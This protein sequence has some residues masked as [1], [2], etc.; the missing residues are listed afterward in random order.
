MI[1]PCFPLLLMRISREELID[2]IVRQRSAVELIGALVVS[3]ISNVLRDVLLCHLFY[4]IFTLFMY[5]LSVVPYLFRTHC[6]SVLSTC[7]E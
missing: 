7:F 1:S 6:V 4:R 5:V 2:E 3:N